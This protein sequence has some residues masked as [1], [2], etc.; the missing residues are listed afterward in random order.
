MGRSRMSGTAAAWPA[1][2]RELIDATSVIS[3]LPSPVKCRSNS[4]R[5]QATSWWCNVSAPTGLT[6]QAARAAPSARLH[7][8]RARD[9]SQTVGPAPRASS[10]AANCRRVSGAFIDGLSAPRTQTA[11][12]SPGPTGAVPHN[13]HRKIADDRRPGRTAAPPGPTHEATVRRRGPQ[14]PHSRIM[15]AGDDAAL[16]PNG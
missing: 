13:S 9:R 12:R 3:S 14:G 5:H 15:R 6:A 4:C 1:S 16:P 11:S 2:W 8:R 7:R 10:R